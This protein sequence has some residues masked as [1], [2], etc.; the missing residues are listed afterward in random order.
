MVKGSIYISESDETG[1]SLD[2]LAA[3]FQVDGQQLTIDGE[4]RYLQVGIPV[5]SARY[6]R[7]IDFDTDGE[8]WAR[9]LPSAYRNGTTYVAVQDDTAEASM[10]DVGA[11]ALIEEVHVEGLQQAR[12]PA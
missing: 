7:L 10:A 5:Y 8:E 1:Q 9:N 6:D 2:R 3:T 4:E 12:E 11:G